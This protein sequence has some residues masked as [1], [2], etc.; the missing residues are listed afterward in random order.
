MRGL[1]PAPGGTF[2]GATT[3]GSPNITATAAPGASVVVGDTITGTDIPAGSVITA[4]SGDT[5]TIDQNATGTATGTTFTTVAPTAVVGDASQA[6]LGV[7]QDLTWK[8]LDQAALFD[9]NGDLIINLPQQDAV[10]LRVVA[11]FGFQVA[12]TATY[13]QPTESSRWPFG[14]AL[15]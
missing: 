8:V 13:D 2:T 7:R 15:G 9:N 3:S 10:A 11:R 4:I 6:L 12:N 14:V 5:V 1:W